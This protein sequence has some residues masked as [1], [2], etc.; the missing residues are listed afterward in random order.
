MIKSFKES[1][2]RNFKRAAYTI[3][4]CECGC[5]EWIYI[6][7]NCKKIESTLNLQ[8]AKQ[9]YKDLKKILQDE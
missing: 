6:K 9:L 2:K 7:N 8:I 1:N 4:F 5:N 3:R